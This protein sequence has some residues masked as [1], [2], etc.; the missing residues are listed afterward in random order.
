MS[1]EFDTLIFDAA[2]RHGVDPALIKA[3]IR[4]ESNFNPNAYRR[5]PFVQ[6][7]GGPDASYGLM[8]TLYTTAQE[9]GYTGTPEGLFHPGVSIEYGTRYLKKQLIRYGGD[10]EK[11]ISAYNAGS[12]RRTS[13]GKWSNQAYVDRVVRFF[14][15]LRAVQAEELQTPTT[16]DIVPGVK[17]P[18]LP[19]VR[20]T[21][22]QDEAGRRLIQMETI[23]SGESAPF[24][25][26]GLAILGAM[27]FSRRKG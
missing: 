16:V 9:L 13:G 25:L 4:A 6:H 2:T 20:I 27:V 21:A 14:R 15:E 10:T 18:A 1:N 23:L 3:V 19:P 22:G 8:Q 26:G 11:A 5:E 7:L 12:A 17:V 24:V